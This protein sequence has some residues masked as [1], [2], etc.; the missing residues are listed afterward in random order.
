LKAGKTDGLITEVVEQEI[1]NNFK[2]NNLIRVEHVCMREK[3]NRK[4]GRNIQARA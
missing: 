1:K 2:P 3:N 4:E